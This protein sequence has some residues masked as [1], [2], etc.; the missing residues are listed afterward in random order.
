MVLLSVFEKDCQKNTLCFSTKGFSLPWETLPKHTLHSS[1]KEFC[2]TLLKTSTC[3]G[4]DTGNIGGG[5]Q[6]LVERWVH[7]HC[8]NEMQTQKLRSL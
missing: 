8:M 3:G 5:E 7:D 1:T 6:A 4:K 2:L